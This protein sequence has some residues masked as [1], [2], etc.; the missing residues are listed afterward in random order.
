MTRI[1]IGSQLKALRKKIK[2]GKDFTITNKKTGVTRKIKKRIKPKN[3]RNI[4]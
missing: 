4:A 3:L 1:K 2:K